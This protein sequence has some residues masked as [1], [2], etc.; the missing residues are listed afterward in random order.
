MSLSFRKQASFPRTEQ[1]F[2]DLDSLHPGNE[3]RKPDRLRP[4][5]RC[6]LQDAA[7]PLSPFLVKGSEYDCHWPPQQVDRATT[8]LRPC[9]LLQQ[10]RLRCFVESRNVGYDQRHTLSARRG[11]Q[12]T[13][14]QSLARSGRMHRSRIDRRPPFRPRRRPGPFF[15]MRARRPRPPC[16]P[17]EH[18][19][20]P[21]RGQPPRPGLSV[22]D[23]HRAA[24]QPRLGL[25]PP[26]ASRRPSPRR[27]RPER[28]SGQA[29]PPARFSWR[30]RLTRSIAS[31]LP[32]WSVPSH[33]SHG[34]NGLP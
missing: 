17:R 33:R 15:L 29:T 2:L 27:S 9:E 8:Q 16:G 31:G 18:H 1:E 25:T 26:A 7:R 20:H 30:R 32:S 3:H 14:S 22:L 11:S 24:K 10:P 23:E 6:F 5:F 21:L 12:H 34:M 19:H 28:T 4:I 13:R